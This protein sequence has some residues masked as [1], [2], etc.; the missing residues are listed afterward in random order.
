LTPGPQDA[1]GFGFTPL[2]F[3]STSFHPNAQGVLK[4]NAKMSGPLLLWSS[5]EAKIAPNGETLPS[6]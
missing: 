4:F 2:Q 6:S 5:V 3:S 1:V